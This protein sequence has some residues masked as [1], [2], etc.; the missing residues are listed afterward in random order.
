M[1]QEYTDNYKQTEEQKGTEA[2]RNEMVELS[3][4]CTSPLV[5]AAKG[6]I[7]NSQRQLYR[8]THATRSL[9]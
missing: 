4:E 3:Y 9:M 5:A 2:R 8:Q 1:R 7:V 6:K